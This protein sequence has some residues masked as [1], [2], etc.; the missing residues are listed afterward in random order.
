[1]P[2]RLTGS[3]PIIATLVLAALGVGAP[4]STARANDCL[5]S[6]NSTAPN[7]SWWYYRLDWPTQRKCWYLRALGRPGQE[8][9]EREAGQRSGS[10]SAPSESRRPSDSADD[11]TTSVPVAD[12]ATV[13]SIVQEVTAPQA[14]TG[15]QT[16]VSTAPTTQNNGSAVSATVQQSA[17]EGKAADDAADAASTDG[18]PRIMAHAVSP[19]DAAA[20][21][22]EDYAA[23]FDRIQKEAANEPPPIS[24]FVIVIGSLA[25]LAIAIYFVRRQRFRGL[26]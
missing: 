6:P 23:R 13:S 1:M 3:V 10:G 14:S 24:V 11:G 9:A 18:A 7:G 4:T 16:S 5:A 25:V 19:D 2:G 21:L 8:T 12:T 20:S 17:H 26:T 15:S 22:P